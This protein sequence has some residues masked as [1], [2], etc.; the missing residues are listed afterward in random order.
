VNGYSYRICA[1]NWSP[2]VVEGNEGNNCSAWSLISI[3][4]PV[5][6]CSDGIDNDG[7]G[8]TDYPNDPGCTDLDDPTE[9]PNPPCSDGID[10]D[11]DGLVDCADPGCWAIPGNSGS[12]DLGDDTED[13]N[14]PTATFTCTSPASCIISPGGSATLTWNTTGYSS[15]VGV[16]FS[17]GGGNPPSGSASVSP[18]ATTAYGLTC[19]GVS[20][21]PVTVS[22][23][24]PYAYIEAVP[25]RVNAGQTASIRYSANQV[26][27]CTVSGTDGYSANPVPDASLNIATTSVNRTISRQTTYTI[28]CDGGAATSRV[29][30]NTT[31]QFQEF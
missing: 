13:P 26:T 9:N 14:P 19:D 10:N 8:Y 5:P 4:A 23:R 7:D 15:C 20:I 21:P 17:T 29:I 11:G 28:S 1:D 18:S 27:T 30:V 22:V 3:S 31:P 25:A 2:T 12:C 16:G 24:Q 6:Q